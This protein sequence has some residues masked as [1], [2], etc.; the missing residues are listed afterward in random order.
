M[1]AC[2]DKNIIPPGAVIGIIGGGQLGRMLAQA[3]ARLGFLTHVYCAAENSPAFAV[4]TKHWCASFDDEEQLADFAK[5]CDIITYEFENIPL[6]TVQ[7]LTKITPVL[8]NINALNI[9]QDRLNERAFLTTNSLPVAP[10]MKVDHEK[11][12]VTAMG[13]LGEKTILKT[14]RLGYDG[15]GQVALSSSP[16]SP[17]EI[18]DEI[19]NQPAILEQKIQFER[20]ISVLV[21]RSANELENYDICENL[22][23]E[24]MLRRT[25]VPAKIEPD[26]GEQ[27]ILMA[28]EIA[29]ALDYVGV[30]AVEMFYCP[31]DTEQPLIINEIAPRVHNSGHW[32]QDGCII[33]QFE[34]HIRAI[35][36]WPLGATRRHSDIIMTN[37]IGEDILEWQ[38]HASNTDSCLHIYGKKEPRD[39]RKMGHMTTLLP[40]TYDKSTSEIGDAD[41]VV[42]LKPLS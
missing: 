8:P 31:A 30:L 11:D 29:I 32:T 4:A 12:L 25:R 18:L 6:A 24:Q 21:I 28:Q 35:C 42:P 16:H 9:T 14:R 36:S 34:N 22:H 15:K 23:L 10:F 3:A 1:I 40:L 27:A 38:N 37:L 20:E 26:I 2:E 33:D 7:S 41:N 13:R 17:Q 19:G 5:S 39:G